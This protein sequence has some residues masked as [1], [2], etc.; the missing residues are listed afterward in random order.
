MS[1]S[2]Q[3]QHRQAATHKPRLKRGSS[4]WIISSLDDVQP[5]DR[6]EW[7]ATGTDIVIWFPP[8]KDPL[9]IGQRR[10]RKGKTFV[11][12]V[13]QNLRKRGVFPYSVFCYETGEMASSNSS[14]YIRVR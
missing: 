13:P 7:K 8:D 12:R 3:D 6:I 2:R 1:N 5:G 14:P 10:V 11:K 4:G 9:G